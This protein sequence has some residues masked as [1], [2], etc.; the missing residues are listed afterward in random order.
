MCLQPGSDVVSRLRQN[1]L[2]AIGLGTRGAGPLFELAM[3]G[4]FGRPLRP[5]HVI[6]AF[7]EGNDWTNLE[8]ELPLPWLKDALLETE[9]YGSRDMNAEQLAKSRQIIAGHIKDKVPVIEML[10]RTRVVRNF[11]ALNQTASL[12]GLAYP[13]NSPMIPEYKTVLERAKKMT[14]G[15]GGELTLLYI[16][17]SGRFY[18]LLP[19]RF[20][21][22]H[23][24]VK[25]MQAA[26]DVG[27]KIIDLAELFANESGP[28]LFYASD[29]HFSERGAAFTA[30]VIADHIAGK[31]VMNVVA[32]QE[33]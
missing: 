31:S 14:G 7:F 13:Q 1:Q 28:H 2:A 6:L 25:V 8:K 32:E 16:P 24:R 30:Q 5:R 10:K 22:D 33:S 23:L 9:D 20:A 18:G 27:I 26:K 4:R 12:M 11:L 29:G 21:Y 15:W 19:H 3:L 17:Q